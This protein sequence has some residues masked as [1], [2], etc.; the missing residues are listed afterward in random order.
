MLRDVPIRVV[1]LATFTLAGI[2]PL[3]VFAM[4][5]QGAA[6]GELVNQAER[7][8]ESVRDLK[9]AELVRFFDGA[10][11]QV[12]VL[13][14]DPSTVQALR[15]L[16]GV[17]GRTGGNA[18]L[19]LRGA[20][21]GEFEAIDAYRRVHDR[22][23]PYLRH[24]AEGHG[25]YDLF[26]MDPETG[27]TLFTVVKE[28]DFGVAVRGTD[29]ALADAYEA[30]AD[31]RRTAIS[32]TRP[33]GPSGDAPAQF[34]AAPVVVDGELLGVV[35]V[36]I[37]IDAIDRIMRERSGMGRTG[38]T[39]LVGA[40]LRMRSDTALDPASHSVVASF[41]G[42]VADNGAD[43][44]AVRAALRGEIA[45][46][47][48]PS[49]HERSVLSAYAPVDFHGLRWAIVA[50]VD[51]AE[52]DA[53]IAGALDTEIT[54]TIALSLVLL[55]VLAF[56]VSLVS[57][58]SI[59]RVIQ[60]LG[61]L[62]DKVLDG[63]GHER[64]DPDELSVDFRDVAVKTNELAA[65]LV[66][67]TK[68][69][70]QLEE[71]LQYNQRMESIGTLAGGI[72]HDFNNVL[73]YLGTYVELVACDLPPASRAR[74]HM[75]EI[76]RGIDRASALVAQIMLFSRQMKKE[77]KPVD[78]SLIVK[79]AVKLLQATLPGAIRVE[80]QVQGTLYVLADP[81]Q[82]HQVV[83]NLC[84]NAFHAMLRTG[85][86]LRVSLERCEL[87]PGE[88][89]LMTAGPCCALSVSDTGEG[90]DP[91][92]VSRV[93]EPFFTTKPVGQGTGMGLAVV[94]G[95]VAAHGGH[96]AIDSAPRHGTTVRVL[97]PLHA[98]TEER[99]DGEAELEPIR[100]QGRVLLVDDEAAI[101]DA[102]GEALTSLGYEV[103]ALTS[104][105][106][107][108]ALVEE[109]PDRYAVVLT[110]LSMPGLDGA[111]LARRLKVLR[112]DLP[113]ILSTGYSERMT[114]QGAAEL[115][116]ACL[117]MKPYKRHALS[118]ALHDA[119]AA[120]MR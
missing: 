9:A 85:G 60:A 79:E 119:L 111:E 63:R 53:S 106:D 46:R 107:A 38:D 114:P 68:E 52:I 56:G 92:I 55:V 43:T 51:E 12:E 93:F 29:S 116:A 102:V 84:T 26:L 11:S 88:H 98:P 10:A 21:R 48:L 33:Y 115:G 69:K 47:Q 95:I 73:T 82:V 105:E 75:D 40:D 59:A 8:L 76:V 30:A 27:F 109:Q 31:G 49:F 113:I 15:D 44:A 83:M 4:L 6:R 41:R 13:A 96:I 42:T 35:A 87:A 62:I 90:I 120:G 36:Q 58:G 64:L 45:A 97:L 71:V 91:A 70:H 16:T 78:V 99:S 23:L 1:L 118:V 77:R 57:S 18:A 61:S 25:F 103:D 22:L 110:D 117:L 50:E 28:A 32:D 5:S 2:I 74:S 67:Q 80:K 81:T 14:A 108:L 112:P 54:V 24:F 72:A 20:S 37:S 86:V 19:G 104:P 65:A 101:C 7:Q 34:V 89:P 17:A 39:Y 3:M 100:G 94:H 66:Q